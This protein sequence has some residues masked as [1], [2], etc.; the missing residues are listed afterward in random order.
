MT[1]IARCVR[2]HS[3]AAPATVSETSRDIRHCAR[4]G[5]APRPDCT[6]LVPPSS[7]AR[8]PASE[9][10]PG[11]DAAGIAAAAPSH[12]AALRSHRLSPSRLLQPR[13]ARACALENTPMQLRHPRHGARAVAL[14]VRS[15][16]AQSPTPTDSTGHRHR[17][18]HR[19]DR[20]PVAVRRRGHRP[21]RDRAQPGALAAA[22]CCAAAPASTWSTRAAWAS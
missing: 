21:R 22:S 19:G 5:K 11:C 4:H 20:R 13:C 12:S 15:P 10:R 6:A 3:G 7:Q 17:H 1:L 14:P 8:R 18:A 16:F 9:L 2:D